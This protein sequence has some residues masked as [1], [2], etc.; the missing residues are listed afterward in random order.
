[1]AKFYSFNVKLS[2]FSLPHKL[3]YY[4]KVSWNIPSLL[5]IPC[6]MRVCSSTTRCGK[7]HMPVMML[8][9]MKKLSLCQIFYRLYSPRGPWPLFQFHDHF[10][11]DR[12]PWTSDQL[13]ARPL[14]KHRTTQTQN[15]HI[16]TP[17]TLSGIR[18]HYPSFWASEDSSCLRPLNYCDRLTLSTIT[19]KNIT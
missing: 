18:T 14:P 13:V 10:T 15:K 16:H 7:P 4:K 6:C 12:T 9:L 1:M 11:D 19:C 17:N 5:F 8:L 2:H 3:S